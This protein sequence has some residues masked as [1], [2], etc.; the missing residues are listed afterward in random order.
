MLGYSPPAMQKM[1]AILLLGVVACGGRTTPDTQPAPATYDPSKNDPK[2][3][4]VVD[5]MVTALG[6]ADKWAAVKQI[7]WDVKVVVKGELKGLY[8]HSW[9]L[10]NA[11]HRF[12]TAPPG[13]APA[14]PRYTGSCSVRVCRKSAPPT[15][16]RPQR[17]RC[18]K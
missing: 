9:D 18:Q 2:A 4:E 1:T 17:Q 16:S 11:R 6:G 13:A 10:W 5:K 14:R 8:K 12:E 15:A 3:L 7:R